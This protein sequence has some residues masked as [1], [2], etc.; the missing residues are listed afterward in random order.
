[1]FFF[2]VYCIFVCPNHLLFFPIEYREAW[3]ESAQT[4]RSKSRESGN[5]A[6]HKPVVM[7]EANFDCAVDVVNLWTLS[8]LHRSCCHASETS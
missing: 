3:N 2:F 6:R 8:S 7:A 4:R 5:W 1:M